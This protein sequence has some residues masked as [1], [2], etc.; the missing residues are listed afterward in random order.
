M[1]KVHEDVDC[2]FCG[3]Q[4]C[5][6]LGVVTAM[7]YCPARATRYKVMALCNQCGS[8]E[9]VD[10]VRLDRFVNGLERMGFFQTAALLRT[11]EPGT[12]INHKE[13][14]EEKEDF[15]K[16]ILRYLWNIAEKDSR[17]P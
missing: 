14:K 4:K 2:P 9:F 5:F 11:T 8:K 1:I 3:S 12:T 13:E 16:R 6:S 7:S 15:L 17:R 10:A